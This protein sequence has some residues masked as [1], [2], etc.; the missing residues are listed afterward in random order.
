MFTVSCA[1]LLVSILCDSGDTWHPGWSLRGGWGG[2]P[3]CITIIE[4]LSS[5][6][7]FALPCSVSGCIR[8]LRF[9][10]VQRHFSAGFSASR[11]WNSSLIYKYEGQGSQGLQVA[12]SLA[13][14]PIHVGK[15]IF[16]IRLAQGAKPLFC[17]AGSMVVNPCN[18]ASPSP[19]TP[20]KLASRCP[21][22]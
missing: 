20:A 8:A 4:Q 18:H 3:L 19:L 17:E 9:K 21:F 14:N 12:S 2:C 13:G 15:Q 7:P 10:D 6:A 22:C 1:A 11:P 16:K 5:C